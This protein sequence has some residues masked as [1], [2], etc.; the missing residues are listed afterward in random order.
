M[1]L[2]HRPHLGAAVGFSLLFLGL[3]NHARGCDYN[4]QISL[5]VLFTASAGSYPIAFTVFY[6]PTLAL[7][8][9]SRS[10]QAG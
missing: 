5:D 9:C 1:P 6:D 10:T 4:L 2:R 3:C 8:L 7:P